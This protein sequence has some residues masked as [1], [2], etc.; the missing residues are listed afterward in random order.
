MAV[1][2][3]AETALMCII[4]F[5]IGVKVAQIVSKG[6]EITIK[7]PNPLQAYREHEAKR[8]AQKEQERLDTI[9]RN[10]EK[11]DGTSKGQEDVP[12]G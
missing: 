12:K 2:L 3:V 6:E 11:Y 5:I 4:C 10:I 8:E 7:A 9:M 1:A